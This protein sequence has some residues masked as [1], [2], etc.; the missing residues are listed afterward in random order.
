M[1]SDR[2]N[3]R[4]AKTS[5]FIQPLQEKY[6]KIFL[7][8][9]LFLIWN[10]HKKSIKKKKSQ[11]MKTQKW[12]TRHRESC[13]LWPQIFTFSQIPKICDQLVR[14]ST[15]QRNDASDGFQQLEIEISGVVNWI[16]RGGGIWCW[17]CDFNIASTV[18]GPLGQ[19]RAVQKC[20]HNYNDSLYSG[21][22]SWI[23][24]DQWN[25]QSWQITDKTLDR[26]SGYI[27]VF[28][29]FHFGSYNLGRSNKAGS[30]MV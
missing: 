20:G 30:R 16:F 19:Q 9:V 29:F 5:I 23:L 21:F 7:K 2:I 24:F 18:F 6:M 8:N 26:N 25:P 27:F 13:L 10:D 17:Y 28:L 3:L 14:F 12:K 22:I 4:N 11:E 1:K 15:D